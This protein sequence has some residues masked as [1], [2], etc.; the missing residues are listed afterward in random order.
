MSSCSNPRND[1]TGILGSRPNMAKNGEYPVDACGVAL[2]ANISSGK[3]FG[4]RRLLSSE[5]VRNKLCIVLL[6]RS[7]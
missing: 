1:S 3:C 7:H 2:Y 4:Q 6:K 5:S